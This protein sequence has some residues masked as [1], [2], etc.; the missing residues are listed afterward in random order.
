MILLWYFITNTYP[1]KKLTIYLT[2]IYTAK[3]F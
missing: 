3:T 1:Y 2:E